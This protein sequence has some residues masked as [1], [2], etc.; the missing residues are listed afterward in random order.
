VTFEPDF[1]EDD[2]PRAGERRER[3]VEAPD[4]LGEGSF[5]VVDRHDDA[6]PGTFA[7][8]LIRVPRTAPYAP[9]LDD[10]LPK[11]HLGLVSTSL[12]LHQGEM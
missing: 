5:A 9:S 7:S 2:L 8:A 4:Q 11:G 3:C 10:W 1:H 6:D 12:P